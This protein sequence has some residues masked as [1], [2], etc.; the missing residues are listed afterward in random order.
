MVIN[1]CF[2]EIEKRLSWYLG[3]FKESVLLNNEFTFELTAKTNGR[4]VILV[5]K[6]NL[7][8]MDFSLMNEDD[9]NLDVFL[10]DEEIYHLFQS[11]ADNVNSTSD[12]YG[13]SHKYSEITQSAKTNKQMAQ[14]KGDLSQTEPN[15]YKT[16]HTKRIDNGY[17]NVENYTGYK[18]INKAEMV[19]GSNSDYCI[20]EHLEESLRLNKPCVFGIK[21]INDNVFA[22]YYR[23][24]VY[25]KGSDTTFRHYLCKQPGT[26]VA[27]R[28][29]KELSS[30]RYQFEQFGLKLRHN[31]RNYLS[32]AQSDQLVHHF[33]KCWV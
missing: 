32:R 6:S 7:E 28:Y 14:T 8:E 19:I 13:H 24:S 3:L 17:E 16:K 12:D 33:T 1:G 18:C 15:L 20:E 23:N 11:G 22:L 2:S 9:E 26:L 25:D 29:F 4:K 10:M 27:Y 31:G 5:N 30:L 21:Y